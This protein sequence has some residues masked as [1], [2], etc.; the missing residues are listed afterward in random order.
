MPDKVLNNVNKLRKEKKVTQ[1][2]LARALGV[3]RQ[4]VIAIEKGNYSPSISLA[5]NIAQYFNKPIE[6][7][8]KLCK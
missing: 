1:E 2:D 4:T 3:S 5:L 8:F 6:K 7:I